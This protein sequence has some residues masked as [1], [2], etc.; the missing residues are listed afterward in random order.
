MWYPFHFVGIKWTE[1]LNALHMHIT[2]LAKLLVVLIDV[3]RC[4]KYEDLGK[5]N[6][7]TK[8]NFFDTWRQYK[9]FVIFG[10]SPPLPPRHLSS[11][12]CPLPPPLKDDV[13][14]GRSHS[15]M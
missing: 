1:Y 8:K 3:K 5:K 2:D 6:L 14:S 4:K 11:S 12:L 9:D 15:I 13:I 10:P 7:D